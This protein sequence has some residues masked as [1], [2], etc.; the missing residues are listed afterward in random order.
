MP[1]RKKY[2]FGIWCDMIRKTHTRAAMKVTMKPNRDIRASLWTLT[3]R[4]GRSG[5]MAGGVLAG[6]GAAPGRQ[7][8]IASPSVAAAASMTASLRVGWAWIVWWISS[9]EASSSMARPYS[10]I[11]SVA[12]EPMMCAP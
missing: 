3:C 1:S 10:A 11:R 9:A 5:C 8:W 4:T 6:R 12:S 2:R 7:M